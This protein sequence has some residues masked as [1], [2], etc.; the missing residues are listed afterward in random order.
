M[1]IG[2]CLILI[3]SILTNFHYLTPSGVR[4]TAVWNR[5]P[6]ILYFGGGYR[7]W[8]LGP[9]QWSHNHNA[10]KRH[11]GS[12]RRRS[13]LRLVSTGCILVLWT[14]VD[15]KYKG[16]NGC[17]AITIVLQSATRGRCDVEAFSDWL[18]V[19]IM[20]LCTVLDDIYEGMRERKGFF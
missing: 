8:Y 16:E 1:S 18:L 10:T 11:Q 6:L 3:V 15:D 19:S 5:K 4:I 12:L 2:S 7:F 14:A 9:R 17:G 13:F 20:L